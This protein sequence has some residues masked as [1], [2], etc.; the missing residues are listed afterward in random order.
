ML[1]YADKNGCAVDQFSVNK[2][3][4]LD[5]HQRL[6]Y[7]TTKYIFFSGIRNQVT[8]CKPVILRCMIFVKNKH[9]ITIYQLHFLNIKHAIVE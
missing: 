2:Q 1:M 4:F 6:K 3:L 8:C 9:F 7:T 5:A